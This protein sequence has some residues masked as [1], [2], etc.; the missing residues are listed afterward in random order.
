MSVIHN[1]ISSPIGN[2]TLVAEDDKLIG[3]YQEGQSNYPK[4]EELGDSDINDVIASAA[5]Q[6]K[7]YFA[8]ERAVFD[9]PLGEADTE[10]KGKVLAATAGIAY[11]AVATYGDVSQKIGKPKSVVYVAGALN[12]NKLTIVIPCHRVIGINSSRYVA[13]IKNKDYLQKLE[14]K[15]RSKFENTKKK[16][17]LSRLFG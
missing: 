12:A 16:G 6:I 9:L 4:Q 15:H 14:S 3:V 8:G 17:L 1:I 13:D 5:K 10:F 11:G 2:I 7:E